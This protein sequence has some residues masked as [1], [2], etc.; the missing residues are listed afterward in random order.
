MQERKQKQ[1]QEKAAALQLAQQVNDDKRRYD[2]EVRAK[3]AASKLEKKALLHELEQGYKTESKRRFNEQR[4]LVENRDEW[5]HKAVL[6]GKANAF[7]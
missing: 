1:D 4:G 3:K 2:E 6:Q 7:V 5:V